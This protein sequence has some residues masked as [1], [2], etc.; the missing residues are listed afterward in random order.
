[1]GVRARVR[2]CVRV[3]ECVRVCV[4]ACESGCACVQCNAVRRFALALLFARRRTCSARCFNEIWSAWS[5]RIRSFDS[6]SS[7]SRVSSSERLESAWA[8]QIG[9]V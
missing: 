1:M 8:A 2:A 5:L 3:Y 7:T 9:P 6:S 4:R